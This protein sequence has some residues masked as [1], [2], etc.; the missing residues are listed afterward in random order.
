MQAITIVT[1]HVRVTCIC[2]PNGQ[3]WTLMCDL[4]SSRLYPALYIQLC[5]STSSCYIINLH[6][7]IMT[8]WQ[9]CLVMQNAIILTGLHEFVYVT[10]MYAQYN[11]AMYR[12]C[13][14]SS[15]PNWSGEGLSLATAVWSDRKPLH[16]LNNQIMDQTS[17]DTQIYPT[18]STQYSKIPP[19]D[20]TMVKVHLSGSNYN[21]NPPWQ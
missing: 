21:N 12:W 8:I 7:W 15:W 3:I 17:S 19:A 4:Y 5:L 2:I 14:R 20:L 11:D 6:C 13:I 1:C 16:K 9:V 10:Y 18:T